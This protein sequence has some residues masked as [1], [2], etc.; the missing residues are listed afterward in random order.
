MPLG[1]LIPQDASACAH[2]KP[3]KKVNDG[4][5][6]SKVGLSVGLGVIVG[7]SV[8]INVGVQLGVTVL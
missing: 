8:G 2:E 3:Q 6:L 4:S 1:H 7:D 5:S